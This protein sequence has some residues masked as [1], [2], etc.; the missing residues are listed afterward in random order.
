MP[1]I[2]DQINLPTTDTSIDPRDDGKPWELCSDDNGDAWECD[3]CENTG[4]WIFRNHE[5]KVERSV[6]C[7]ECGNPYELPRP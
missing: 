4:W 3:S 7:G 6:E 5:T 2:A 1:F